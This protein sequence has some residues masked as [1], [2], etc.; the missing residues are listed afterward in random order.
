MREGRPSVEDWE[1]RGHTLE[2]IELYVGYA[3][4]MLQEANREARENRA[5]ENA[6]ELKVDW[7]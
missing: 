1:D 6:Y 2:G 7:K 4:R 5:K 3:T